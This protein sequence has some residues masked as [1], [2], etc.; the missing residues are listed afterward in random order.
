MVDVGMSLMPPKVIGRKVLLGYQVKSPFGL[1]KD[2]RP[3]KCL[4]ILK[5][6]ELKE[7]RISM[8]MEKGGVHTNL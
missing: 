8:K 6:Y 3:K 2:F 7:I 4:N 5:K 1:S